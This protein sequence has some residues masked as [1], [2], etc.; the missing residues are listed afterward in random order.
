LPQHGARRA[1]RVAGQ[2]MRVMELF[3]DKP[4][5]RAWR[6]VHARGSKNHHPGILK[7]RIIS[8]F[9]YGYQ[10]Y[11]DSFEIRLYFQ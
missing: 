11:Q 1:L 10:D 9:A 6:Q 3:P 7:E 5:I 2:P 4:D 8:Q